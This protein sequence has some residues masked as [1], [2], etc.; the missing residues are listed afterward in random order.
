MH[1]IEYDELH[2]ELIVSNPFA[3]AILTFRGDA[4]GEEPPIRVIQGPS[5][6]LD[7]P[8]RFAVDPVH[9]E[10]FVPQESEI[11]VLPRQANGDATPIRRLH[12][13]W[14]TGYIAV[15]PVH[16]IIVA[17]G[18][19]NKDPKAD[20][21]LLIFNRTDNG[22]VKP[23]AVIAGPHTGIQSLHQ[24][25]LY[26]DRGWIVASQFLF[27]DEQKPG[28][29]FVGIW[30]INDAGD[31]P[32]RW[33]LGGPKTTL[34]RVRGVVVN[35]KYKEIIIADMVLNAALTYYFPEIF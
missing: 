26:P 16:N 20:P 17:T 3:Q 19:A 33:K 5:T 29:Y 30:S 23:R 10:I 12:G 35:P 2:D 8:D 11:L 25:Q 7:A 6:M 31:I 28:T 13:Q 34:K 27:G 1:A 4:N 21:A 9:N 18:F 22:E 15:D 24:L 14:R 32:P